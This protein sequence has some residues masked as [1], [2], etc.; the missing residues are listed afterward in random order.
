MKFERNRCASKQM[1]ACFV[2]KFGHFATIPLEDRKTVTDDWYV[3]HCVPK[4]FQATCKR[5]PQMG[6]HGLLLH[7]DN[8]S[9]HTSAVTLDFVAANDFQLVIP[10]PYSPDLGPSDWFL[11]CQ[12]AAEGKAVSERRRCPRIHRGRHFGHTPV[13]VVVCHKQLV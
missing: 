6:V 9:M 12:L 11:F 5:C 8:A 7:H 4:I 1:L 10:P 2:A 3:N 13:N